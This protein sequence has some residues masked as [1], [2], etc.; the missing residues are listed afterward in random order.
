MGSTSSIRILLVDGHPKFIGALRE[1]MDAEYGF[2]VVGE[3]SGG[4]HAVE[5][6]TTLEPDVTLVDVSTQM[7]HGLCAMRRL[8]HNS[9]VIVLSLDPQ[10]WLLFPVLAAGARGFVSKTNVDLDLVRAIKTVVR[11]DVFLDRDGTRLLRQWSK[12]TANDAANLM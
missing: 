1:L 10:E 6:A 4:R 2:C 5:Q 3:A 12:S 7:P 8:S 11:G 9:K